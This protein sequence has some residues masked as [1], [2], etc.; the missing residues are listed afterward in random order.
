MTRI[1]GFILYWLMRPFVRRV[2]RKPETRV[3][4]V[5]DAAE[6]LRARV[7]AANKARAKNERITENKKKLRRKLN[8]KMRPR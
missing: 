7:H 3:F 6:V 8:E 5:D 4:T 1:L 2:P